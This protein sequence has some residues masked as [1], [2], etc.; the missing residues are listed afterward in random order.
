MTEEQK[1]SDIGW[2]PFCCRASKQIGRKKWSQ[3]KE[4]EFRQWMS[5]F[6]NEAEIASKT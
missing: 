2:P 3:L 6:D 4:K 1:I 5:D